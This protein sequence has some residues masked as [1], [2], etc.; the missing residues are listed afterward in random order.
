MTRVVVG[1]SGRLTAGLN[2]LLA[3]RATVGLA[4][5]VIRDGM[6]EFHAHGLADIATGRP[7]G[8]DTVFRIGSITKT[9]TAI[10]VMQLLEQGVVDLDAPANDYLRAYRLIPARARFRPATVRHLL[11]HTAGISEQVPRSGMLRRDFGETVP[12]GARVPSLAEYYRGGLRLEA[13]PGTRFRYGDHGIATLGQLVEDVTGQPFHDYL[14]EHV[15]T[16]LGMLDT[17][18]LRA[19]ADTARLVTG[20]RLGAHGPRAVPERDFVPAGA[21]A[22]FS[23]PRDMARYLAAFLGGGGN[24]HG[25]VLRPATLAAM[26]APQYQP[27]P[28]LPGLGLA[29]FRAGLGAHATVEHQGVLPPHYAQIVVAPDAGAA[30]MVFTNGAVG[31]AAWLPVEANLL[32][33]RE[34]DVPDDAVRRDVPQRPDLWNELCGWYAMPGPATLTDVRIRGFFGAGFEVLVRRGTLVLRL[35]SPVPVLYRG[36]P[37]HPD[38]ENDP[39]LYRVDL[40]AYHLGSIQIAFAPDGAGSVA[41][42]LA[43]PMPLSAEQRSAL[44]NPRLWAQCTAAVTATSL[45][46]TVLARRTVQGRTHRTD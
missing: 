42:H 9:F 3:R 5:G 19:E 23:T 25:R 24:E 32:L 39:Y 7:V 20:Y 13:E 2:E 11:T 41:L 10:A 1:R 37:L 18:L 28:R 27:D 44:S 15:F 22:I 6:L 33:A 30:V 4:A 12:A 34:L 26:F 38:D 40:S 36:F 14:R 46:A 35:L 16:P 45:A 17:T 29:F 8:L 43:A 21:G 31:A